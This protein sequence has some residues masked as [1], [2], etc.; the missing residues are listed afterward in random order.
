S[1]LAPAVNQ[2]E[3]SGGERPTVSDGGISNHQAAP[4][5][6]SQPTG[7]SDVRVVPIR[8]ST[9]PPGLAPSESSLG[10]VSVLYPVVA[11]NDI[12][13][14]VSNGSQTHNTENR[15]HLVP[16][17]TA[18]QQPPEV[19]GTTHGSLHSGQTFSTEIPSGLDQL[20]RNLFPDVDT[21]P[22]PNF[23][24]ET[25]A[26]SDEGAFLSNLLHQIMPIV[27]QH[28]NGGADGE[29]GATQPPS[30]VE[31]NHDRG[32]SS[33]QQDDPSSPPSSKRQ[34]ALTLALSL[35]CESGV[36][37]CPYDLRFDRVSYCKSKLKPRKEQKKWVS[38]TDI[39]IPILGLL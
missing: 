19:P 15:P 21:A 11:R 33:R 36:H 8:I 32:A 27:T 37:H 28:L 20:L 2:R 14:H 9:L 16:N 13:G 10:S 34:K 5:N 17:S 4:R 1:V 31:E 7:A 38:A 12:N 25:P 6:M 30:N 26:V 3:A 22:A 18:Q 35:P 39:K 24:Q 23:T 29:N